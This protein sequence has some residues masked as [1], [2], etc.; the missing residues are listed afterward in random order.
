MTTIARTA[1]GV[2]PRFAP[3]TAE[4]FPGVVAK[5]RWERTITEVHVHHTWKPNESTYLK[6]REKEHIIWGM[7]DFHTRVN[8]WS[9]LAQHVTIAPDGLI[10]MG[11]SWN[12]PPASSGGHNGTSK[13]GPFMLEI[14]G[15]YD[16]TPKGTA[17]EDL[18]GAGWRSVLVVVTTMLR[19]AA[20]PRTAVRFHRQLGSPKTCPGTDLDYHGFLRG[21]EAFEHGRAIAQFLGFNGGEP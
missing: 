14:I 17:I 6:A 5:Y 4:M 13:A 2:A 10:W 11:R 19:H 20:L 15:N 8:G 12:R 9:D 18:D 7:W 16:R 21:L 1:P 3:V